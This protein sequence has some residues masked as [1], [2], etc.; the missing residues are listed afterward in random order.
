MQALRYFLGPAPARAAPS[1]AKG[2]YARWYFVR[3]NLPLLI[4]MWVAALIWA[5]LI[6]LV[7]LAMLTVA[8][9][10]NGPIDQRSDS[11]CTAHPGHRQSRLTACVRIGGIPPQALASQGMRRRAT[12]AINESN[13]QSA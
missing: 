4:V 2:A 6:L 13:R 12:F 10:A 5:P 9:I 3:I 7:F 1:D 8:W 11:R